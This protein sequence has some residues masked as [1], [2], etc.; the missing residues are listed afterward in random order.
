[1]KKYIIVGVCLTLIVILSAWLRIVIPYNDVIGQGEVRFT[2]V[3]AY[4][5][6]RM[7]DYSYEH[8][9]STMT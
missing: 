3:D 8:F 1:M 6:M 9:P 7:A 4:T 5:H 2:T